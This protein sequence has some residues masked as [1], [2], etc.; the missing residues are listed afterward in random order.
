MPEHKTLLL[1]LGVGMMCNWVLM[2]AMAEQSERSEI[3]FGV[4]P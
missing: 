1:R 2:C 4:F 3:V